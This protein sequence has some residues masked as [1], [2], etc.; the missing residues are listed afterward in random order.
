M[1]I[2]M[3][4]LSVYGSE[5]STSPLMEFVAVKLSDVDN[6]D[7]FSANIGDA[8]EVIEKS[9]N[10]TPTYKKVYTYTSNGGGDTKILKYKVTTKEWVSV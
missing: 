7:Y 3:A 1:V 4:E 8:K 6:K 5:S 2:F 10:G 9:K